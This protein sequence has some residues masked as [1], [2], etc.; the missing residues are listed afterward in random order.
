MKS[1]I[2]KTLATFLLLFV[3]SL[4]LF[5]IAEARSVKIRGYYKRSTG[6]YIMPHYRTSPNRSKWDNWS[7]KGNI[8]PYT[9]RRGTVD[10][11]RSY[12]LRY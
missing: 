4:S 2:K 6:R 10:P 8:N 1:V 9:G 3:M 5:G 7:T 11:W 12:R